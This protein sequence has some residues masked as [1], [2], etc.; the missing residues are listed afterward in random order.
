MEHGD[1]AAEHADELHVVLDHDDGVA[2][3]FSSRISATSALGLG[4][5][6]AGGRLVEEDQPR[7]RC[8][9]TMAELD[10]LA[11]AVRELADLAPGDA[12]ERRPAEH[13]GHGRLA[14]PRGRATRRAASHR[15]SRTRQAVRSP[16]APGS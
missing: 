5:G 9:I 15:F 1:R 14:P 13:L 6:H 7:A 4:T 3:R 2:L 16:T 12:C 11:L 8:A 10:Q